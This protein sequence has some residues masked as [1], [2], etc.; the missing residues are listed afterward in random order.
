MDVAEER[1]TRSG[2]RLRRVARRDGPWN[3]L[4]VPG[5]PG[6]GSESVAGLA[7]AAAVPGTTWL[8]D[9]PGDGSNRGPAVPARP[10]ERWPGVLAEAVEGLERTVMVGH[11]TG[12]MFLLSVPEL[13]RRLSGLVLV[14]SAPHA[15]WRSGFERW[16]Q[17][18]PLPGLAEA[19]ERYAAA[20]GDATLRELTVAAAPWNFTPD[21]L[22][23]GRALLEGL[24]YCH[25]AVAWADVHF[26]ADYRAL[27]TPRAVPTLIVGGAEDRLVDQRLWDEAPGFRQPNIVRRTI[28]AAGHFPWIDNPDAV[29]D[30]FAGMTGRLDDAS[31]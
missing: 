31:A 1:W 23:Q 26:D 19:A 24:P 10:F 17:A 6:L 5:G 30:A 14:S 20:P 11:S 13:E 28:A 8:V 9:L 16:A 27:W 2:V 4:F 12:G 25:D 15:G 3:W 29:R 22:P 18:H 21:G 7:Q